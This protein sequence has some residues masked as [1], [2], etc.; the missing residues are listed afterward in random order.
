MREQSRAIAVGGVTAAMAVVFLCMGTLLPL[1]TYVCPM[2]CMVA[3][4]F[5]H[6]LCGDRIAWA[7]YAAVTILAILMGPDKEAAGVFAFLGYYPIVKP[8]LDRLRWGFLGKLLLFNGATM[9]L[10]ACLIYLLGL[11]E[12]AAEFQGAGLGMLAVMLALGNAAFFLLDR[13]LDK[14]GKRRR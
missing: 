8:K 14:L 6:R 12:V 3:L 7:W 10:Y 4:Y 2:L 13:L 5:V 9:A 11:E 1:A